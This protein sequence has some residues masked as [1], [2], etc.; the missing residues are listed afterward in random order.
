M[1]I[2]IGSAPPWSSTALARSYI[3]CM[4][5]CIYKYMYICM[6]IT[7]VVH[8]SCSMVSLSLSLY[9][10]IYSG[11]HLGRPQLLLDGLDRDGEH[12]EHHTCAHSC[13]H[14]Y[15]YVYMCTCI[16]VY[17]PPVSFEITRMLWRDIGARQRRRA[18]SAPH[19]CKYV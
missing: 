14:V 6:Y 15:M 2:H 18:S 9:I 11:S 3:T 13:V 19:L 16:H 17:T 7:L 4:C 1:Y 5:V 12:L 10:Y 8:S